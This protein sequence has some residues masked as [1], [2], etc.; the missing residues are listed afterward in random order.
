MR[1]T[2]L[3]CSLRDK[4]IYL[5]TSFTSGFGEMM[6]FHF[7]YNNIK[8]GVILMSEQFGYCLWG[9]IDFS[10]LSLCSLKWKILV[11]CFYRVFINPKNFIFTPL[12]V[13]YPGSP[14]PGLTHAQL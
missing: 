2:K 10:A 7:S 12:G 9:P 1:Y 11:R 8:F 13:I 14:T 4:R 6:L 5:K 3:I